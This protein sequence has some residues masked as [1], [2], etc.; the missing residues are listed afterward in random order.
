MF[1]CVKLNSLIDSEIKFYY[2]TQMLKQ[3]INTKMIW[4]NYIL[5]FKN[6]K[7]QV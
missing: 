3:D 5:D 2:V 1:M 6:K 7:L 4:P